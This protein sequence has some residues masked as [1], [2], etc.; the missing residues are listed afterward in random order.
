MEEKKESI[1]KHHH[2][3]EGH[4]KHSASVKFNIRHLYF[5][6]LIVLGIVLIV[7]MVLTFNINKDLQK[8]SAELKEKLKP[9]EVELTLIRNSKCKDCAD[10][11][12]VVSSIKNAKINITKERTLEF[13]SKEAKE[14]ISKYK[15]QRI[16]TVLL[17]GEIEKVSIQ[18]MT[19]KDNALLLTTI[20]PPYTNALNGKIEGKATLY[21]IRD[22]DCVKCGDLDN[23]I[24]QIKSAGVRISNE[25]N[26]SSK[27][28][29]G[30]D[31]IRK[32][33][34]SFVPS[35]ILSKDAGAYDIVQKAWPQIGTKESDGSY[36]L[37][38]V[39][40]PYINLT[41]GEL[42]GVVSAIYITDKSCT[43]CYDISLHRQILTSPQS[44]AIKLDKE[45]T[46]DLSDAKGKEIIAKYDITAVPTV[47]LSEGI[48]AYPTSPA[49]KQFFK[50]AEDG[51]FIFNRVQALGTYKNLTSGEIIK[52][53][54]QEAQGQEQA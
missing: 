23:I 4:K 19:K 41:T 26:M 30:Q 11:S 52:P 48:N 53:Q 46:Y 38:L 21:V 28:P 29:E 7:N 20:A 43:E 44:F 1:E 35:L 32:Y 17:T 36:I 51:F 3:N 24:A 27:S 45:E 9:G 31:L 8:K 49:L 14:L 12:A 25:R 37:R 6:L 47:I 50:V 15:I 42:K 40:P 54:Q 22:P 33:N 34:I 39:Y 5:G 16:P 18:G 13:D 2:H 10:I